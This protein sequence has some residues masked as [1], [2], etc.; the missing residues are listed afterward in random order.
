M[1]RDER[2]STKSLED[3]VFRRLKNID[4]KRVNWLKICWMRSL[5]TKPYKMFYK[6]SM[7]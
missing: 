4:G 2:I 3:A 7:N 5:E 6:T 1:K